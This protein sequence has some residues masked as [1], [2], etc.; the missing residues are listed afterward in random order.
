RVVAAAVGEGIRRDV[1]HAHDQRA[2]ERQREPAADEAAHRTRQVHRRVD[3]TQGAETVDP[4]IRVR[5]HPRDP[6]AP[7]TAAIREPPARRAPP[8]APPA[9][10]R[11]PR[12][13]IRC[14]PKSAPWAAWAGGP[15]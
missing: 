3:T 7:A 5:P 2:I 4:S 1:H 14:R 11:W 13:R 8:A 15:P 6:R 12:R 9:R 10:W